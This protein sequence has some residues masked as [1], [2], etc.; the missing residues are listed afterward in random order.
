M[1]TTASPATTGTKTPRFLICI[2]W[3]FLTACLLLPIVLVFQYAFSAGIGRYFASFATSDARSAIGL[4]VI[5][6]LIVVPI[7]TVFGVALAWSIA[8]FE[9]RGKNLL[10]TVLDIPFAVSPVIAGMMLILLF[11]SRGLLGPW[12][13]EI[14]VRIVFARPG[15]ILATLFVTFPFVAR[16]LIPLMHS[17]GSEAEVSALS[18]GANGFQ[19]FFRVT[20]PNIKWGLLYGV[21]LTNA[22]AFG[23]FGAVSVVSGHIRGL[24]NTVP[25]HVEI[26]FN[27]YQ[28][29][30]SF[31]VA[32][33]LV[34]LGLVTLVIKIIAES[35]EAQ[36]GH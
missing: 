4:S 12:L 28:F 1:K 8:K 26:L 30:A 35:K 19:S 17:Q 23:E 7:N 13:Q 5:T 6:A 32:S 15:V 27:D 18:L 34:L 31:A 10:M 11:G 2:T 3:L 16:E 9:F 25:L 33:L 22:R 29:A 20:L 24:T 36:Y 21:L 14:G